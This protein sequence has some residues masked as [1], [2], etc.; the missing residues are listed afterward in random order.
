MNYQE[1]LAYLYDQL[2]MFSRVGAAA[3]KKDLHNIIQLV[4][5]LGHPEQ[6]F[7][8]IHIAGTNGKGSTSHMLASIFQE[9]GF[10]TG[11]YTSPHLIDFRERIKINGID[12]PETS[13][14]EFVEKN[15]ALFEQIQPSFFEWTLALC[16]DY[17]AKEKVDIAIIETGLGGRLDSTNIISPLM[18]VITN[19][20]LDHTDLLGNDLATIAFEKAGIIKW[21][22]PVVIGE[23][24]LETKPVFVKKASDEQAPIYFANELIQVDS[25]VHQG[26]H[27][28]FTYQ[29]KDN[30]LTYQVQSP[31]QGVYQIRNI[32]T[33]LA[34]CQLLQFNLLKDKAAAIELGIAKTIENT[35]LLGR[36][37]TVQEKPLVICDTGHN[38]HGMRLIVEQL[39]AF[40]TGKLHVVIGMVSDK[41]HAAVLN[42][43]PKSASY[44]FTKAQLPRALNELDL[45]QMALSYELMGEAYPKV[46]TAYQAA[47]K[48][49]AIEDLIFIGGSTFVVADFL[50]W[51]KNQT[52]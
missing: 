33:V 21:Q 47:A 7:K 36:W 16:F 35:G 10:K 8:S 43:L 15:T 18:S 3:Y 38:E 2:P 25:F 31:L 6:Q 13:V 51:Q 46:E 41:S 49:A 19:I 44:Y 14:V 12:I 11:L 4:D 52:N 1:T 26:A 48:A 45:K 42:L 20:G 30:P 32:T 29:L 5:N 50:I 40:K 39:N 9:A 23:T 34:A 22:T 27:S 24:T 37:Q 28:L 17:F